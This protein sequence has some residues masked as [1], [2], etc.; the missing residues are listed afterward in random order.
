MVTITEFGRDQIFHAVKGMYTDVAERPETGFH[1]PTGR[2][3]CEILGYPKEQLDAIPTTALESFAGVGYPHRCN[4]IK[5]GN[6]VLDI[7]A[8][9]GT[10][11]FIASSLT[12]NEG[13][14][15]G[16]D[17]TSAMHE[18]LKRNIDKAGITNVVPLFGNAEDIPL[19]DESVDVVTSN[20]V[21]NLVPDKPL[22]FD[23]IYRVLKPGG[24]LQISDIVI[25]NSGDE[26]E[27]SKKNPKLWAECIVGA[28][29]ED[30]Y[31]EGSR[32]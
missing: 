29:Y 26:L 27:E 16:L 15:Y 8:G 18:K 1:F 2:G 22:V 25:Q 23:E 20:G 30:V 28:L 14:V 13:K 7:G 6:M 31:I 11:V 21:L 24:R 17:M 4:V 9:A 12:G 5:Q 3:I 19:E 32:I 10:D